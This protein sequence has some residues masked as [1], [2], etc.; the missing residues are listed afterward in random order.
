MVGDGGSGAESRDKDPGQGSVPLRPPTK[1]LDGCVPPI[2]AAPG[3]GPN[4]I[5][6]TFADIHSDN[7]VDG[8]AMYL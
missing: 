2:I 3:A 7:Y 5:S 8:D 1:M 4:E 6:Q